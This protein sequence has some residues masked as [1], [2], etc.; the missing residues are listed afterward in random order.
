MTNFADA[1]AAVNSLLDNVHLSGTV[2]Y[3]TWYYPPTVLDEDGRL[4]G[5]SADHLDRVL[6]NRKVLRCYYRSVLYDK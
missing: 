2:S 1:A 5:S 3:G 4:W 6:E